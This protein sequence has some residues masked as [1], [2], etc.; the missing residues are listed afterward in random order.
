MDRTANPDRVKATIAIVGG[1]PIEVFEAKRFQCDGGL[2]ALR[3]EVG[4]V[5]QRAACPASDGRAV[6]PRLESVIG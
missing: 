5:R 1:V 6:E 3:V 2:A 4:A